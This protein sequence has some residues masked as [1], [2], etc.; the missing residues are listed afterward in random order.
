MRSS[1]A[2]CLPMSASMSGV[3]RTLRKV[4][5]KGT[6]IRSTSNLNLFYWSATKR[7]SLLTLFHAIYL[8]LSRLLE[9]WTEKFFEL[10]GAGANVR[11]DP[12]EV[13]RFSLDRRLEGSEQTKRVKLSSPSPASTRWILWRLRGT[14]NSGCFEG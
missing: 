4:I 2:V 6:R 12:R 1:F 9:K 5:F 7:T 11:R 10:Y 14:S 3:L 13:L 8:V